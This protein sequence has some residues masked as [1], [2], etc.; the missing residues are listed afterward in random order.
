MKEKRLARRKRLFGGYSLA[1]LKG[2]QSAYWGSELPKGMKAEELE[3][4]IARREA[5]A[6][7]TTVQPRRGGRFVKVPK[8][9]SGMVVSALEHP[10]FR[11]IK[12]EM[13]P[14]RG[15]KKRVK[16]ERHVVDLEVPIPISDPPLT[17]LVRKVLREEL[18]QVTPRRSEVL[19]ALRGVV[20][21][22]LDRGGYQN[23]ISDAVKAMDQAVKAMNEQLQLLTEFLKLQRKPTTLWHRIFG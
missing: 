21:E 1:D 3:A 14:L 10:R 11:Q 12:S 5:I 20:R 15:I 13:Q 2:M 6:K 22:E 19:E 23:Y 8:I 7:N 9:V 4:E 17:A 16:P 18:Q